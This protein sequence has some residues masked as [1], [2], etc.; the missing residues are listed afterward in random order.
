LQKRDNIL[1]SGPVTVNSREVIQIR[2][3]NSVF[4]GYSASC[5]ENKSDLELQASGG[6]G[7]FLSGWW[8]FVWIVNQTAW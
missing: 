5:K 6:G 7:W 3:G 8:L 4:G 1:K 2:V